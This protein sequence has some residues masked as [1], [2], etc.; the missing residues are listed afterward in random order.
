MKILFVNHTGFISGGELS[1]LDLLS[2][3][4]GTV[5]ACIACPS[6]S[7]LAETARAGGLNV[8]AIPAIAGSLRLDRRETPRALATM[9]AAAAV[10][11]R[12]VRHRHVDL[13]HANSI[14]AALVCLPAARTLG[15]PLVAHIRDRLPRSRVAD[16][17]LRAIAVGARTM[18]ANSRFT[19]EGVRAVTS[20]GQLRVIHSP[21]D[22][23]RFAAVR[24]SREPM[25]RE[26][27]IA[28]DAFL[29]AVVGQITPWK[30][31][32]EAVKAVSLLRDAGEAAHLLVV[33]EPTFVS[34]A[35][36]YD[37][38]AYLTEIR[39]LVAADGLAEH[40]RLLGKRDDVPAIMG[41][42]DTL[43]VPSWEEPFGRVVVEGM[44]AG[45]PVLATAVGGPAEIVTDGVDG[46]LVA[47]RDP[48]RWAS[49]IT[50]LKRA[51]V[52]REK[53]GEAARVRAKEF[54]LETHVAKTCAVYHEV[55]SPSP[56]R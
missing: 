6:G 42:L 34:A 37:N 25:R 46:L 54:A 11:A 44:A 31:Q 19:G 22:I 56:R 30:G 55:L 33:G 53:L 40:V 45:L 10:I 49:A 3:L 1:L 20:R 43:I 51:P 23:R 16:T 39:Q 28:P 38:D 5:D 26:L 29:L 24:A 8:A 48:H 36:R 52:Q 27:G 18:L 4:P 41:A 14:R 32:L 7:P 13:I 47:P 21:V 35:T 17:S 15:V 2:V 12:H 9:S 50:D